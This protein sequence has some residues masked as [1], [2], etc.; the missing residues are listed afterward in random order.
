MGAFPPRGCAVVRLAVSYF[1]SIADSRHEIA[2]G[3]LDRPGREN[4]LARLHEVEKQLDEVEEVQMI[5]YV[6]LAR[7]WVTGEWPI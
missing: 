1:A 6:W 2:P 5:D 7:D 4:V 3:R